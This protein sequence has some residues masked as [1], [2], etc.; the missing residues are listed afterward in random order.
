MRYGGRQR[1]MRYAEGG[2][3]VADIRIRLI[4]KRLIFGI[5]CFLNLVSFFF[6]LNY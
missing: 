2:L 5:C 4:R 1:Q 6:L 3:F